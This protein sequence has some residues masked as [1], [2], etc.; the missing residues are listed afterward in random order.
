MKDVESGQAHQPDQQLQV[1][2]WDHI[3]QPT[4]NYLKLSKIGTQSQ[5]HPTKQT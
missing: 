1:Q 3:H 2:T 5:G 4:P